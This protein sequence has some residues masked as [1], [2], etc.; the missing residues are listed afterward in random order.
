MN[1]W[2]RDEYMNTKQADCT[3]SEGA[4]REAQQQGILI[5]LVAP[6]HFSSRPTQLIWRPRHLLWR[7]AH[8]AGNKDEAFLTH[9]LVATA[10]GQQSGWVTTAACQRFHQ[11]PPPS[12]PDRRQTEVA[13]SAASQTDVA[14][15]RARTCIR[16]VFGGGDS[17]ADAP[18][19]NP[20]L[21]PSAGSPHPIL[22]RRQTA[23]WAWLTGP[24]VC[25]P[26]QDEV[27]FLC[28]LCFRIPDE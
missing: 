27:H 21:R 4:F 24:S 2:E 20:Q 6:M 7:V 25:F 3:A 11:S 22:P 13:K 26:F 10:S 8:Q 19:R 1:T 18:S 9:G 17:W 28:S 5:C 15:S 14:T 23:T 16:H 12:A